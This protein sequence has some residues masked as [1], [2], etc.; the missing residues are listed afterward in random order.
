MPSG[1]AIVVDYYQNAPNKRW[2]P[3]SRPVAEIPIAAG[4]AAVEGQYGTQDF[5]VH[6]KDKGKTVS[7]WHDLPLKPAGSTA[8]DVYTGVIEIPMYTTAKLEVQK[9]LPGMQ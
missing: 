6:I 5:T 7:P 3:W 4:T 1:W 8:N 2:V 9:A